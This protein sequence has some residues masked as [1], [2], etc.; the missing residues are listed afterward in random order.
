MEICSFLGAL[1]I[2]LICRDAEKSADIEAKVSTIFDTVMSHSIADMVNHLL[3][4]L[5][6]KPDDLTAYNQT[7]QLRLTKLYEYLAEICKTERGDDESKL[8]EKKIDSGSTSN[9]NDMFEKIVNL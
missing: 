7:V 1:A 4:C 2:N 5:P 3:I 8:D 6:Y 9:L